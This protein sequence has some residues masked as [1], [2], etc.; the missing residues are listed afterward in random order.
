MSYLVSDFL[1]NPVLRQARRFSEVSRSTI[2]GSGDEAPGPQPEAVIDNTESDVHISNATPG[3]IAPVA[4]PDLDNSTSSGPMSALGSL[5]RPDEVLASPMAATVDDGS[6]RDHLGFPILPNRRRGS[7]IPEDDGMAEMR[8][9]IQEIYARDVSPEEKARLMHSLHL[10]R[11]NA[12]RAVPNLQH[13]AIGSTGPV[14]QMKEELRPQ[15]ALDSLMFWS[16]TDDNDTEEFHLT[17]SDLM[18]SWAPS[19]PFKSQSGLASGQIT[20]GASAEAMS[21]IIQPQLGCQHYERN[22]K[23]QCNTCRKWYPCRF[24]HDE[25]MGHDHKL[26][27]FETRYMLCMLCKTPQKAS[28]AC[29]ACQEPSAYY[30]CGI[31]KLWENRQ[32]KPIY[33][34][35][36]CGI[37]RKGH[38]IGKDFFHCLTCCACIPTNIETT[39]KCI[40]RST[41]CDC[42]ICGEYLFTSPRPVVFMV[43]GHSIHKKCYDQ[44]MS[45]S[46]KCPICN[47]SLANME[48][49]FRNLDIAIQSQPMPAEFRDTRAIVLC[50]DCSGRSMV[51]YH[52]LG[53]K[54]GTCQSYNTFQLQILG[55]NSQELQTALEEGTNAQPEQSGFQGQAVEATE[56]IIP[57][58]RRRHS[59]QGIEM[60]RR[61]S[62]AIVGSYPPPTMR[63]GTSLENIDSDPDETNNGIFGFWG[64]GSVD[65]DDEYMFED[66]SDEDSADDEEDDDDDAN[67]ILLI[68]HR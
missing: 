13:I 61:V 11:Y 14:G 42:P 31:C 8:R 39:H 58:N 56:P 20:P 55:S 15:G 36:D 38:G 3:L 65:D 33:H 19:R 26:P 57:A 17:E 2:F 67:E 25:E 51:P 40:E 5:G 60:Q 30:Y 48:T 23:L 41:D 6:P 4:C 12:S 35:Y 49:Q 53:T 46:Y 62:E 44:H 34:C 59:S 10:E 1:I 43:C 18:P 27:R 68:G 47:K 52:W 66:E 9:R 37:C 63:V 54:C 50:N 29:V 32:D 22:V 24:C 28:E 16:S 21:E 7:K 45:V 64:R